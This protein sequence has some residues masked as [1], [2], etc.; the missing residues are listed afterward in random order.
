MWHLSLE[1]GMFRLASLIALA[2]LTVAATALLTAP[3]KRAEDQPQRENDS[4]AEA[5]NRLT[6]RRVQPAVPFHAR[7]SLN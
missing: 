6:A 5:S 7:F 3:T 2:C 1:I 4:D